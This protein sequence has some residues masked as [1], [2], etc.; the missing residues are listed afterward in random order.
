MDAE[1]ERTVIHYYPRRTLTS[2]LDGDDIRWDYDPNYSTLKAILADLKA[3]DPDVRPGTRGHYDISE[4]LVVFKTLHLQ[5]SYLGAFAAI[6]H[7]LERDLTEDEREAQRR[8]TRV[9]EKHGVRLL[10]EEELKERVPWIQHT[11]AT[12]WDCLFVL[13]RE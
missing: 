13:P 7:G 6:N 3:F 1:L 9:L 10:A 11:A 8:T 2:P 5:L 12:I 4:E